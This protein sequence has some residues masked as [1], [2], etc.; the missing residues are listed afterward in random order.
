MAG[1][2]IAGKVIKQLSDVDELPFTL[3]VV[4][5]VLEED[6]DGYP[7]LHLIET[8]GICPDYVL[9][10]EPTDLRVY[11][12][13]RGRMEI[14]IATHGK[15]AHGAHNE[16]GIS[17]V[18]RMIPVLAAIEQLDN[19]LPPVAPLGKGSIT[20]SQIV[21]RA[22]S[23]C[24]VPDYCKIHLDRR[25]TVN[26]TRTSAVAQLE[27]LMAK[28][29]IHGEIT[30]PE[31]NGRSWK[32]T[33]VRQEAYFPTW[34]VDEDCPLVRAGVRTAEQILVPHQTTSFWSFSTN[35]VATA[36]RLGIPTIGFAPGREELAHSSREELVLADLFKATQF[37]AAFPFTLIETLQ[38][39][40]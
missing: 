23:L 31:Y 7:L 29:G 22:P 5:S 10:G 11:R 4:G 15:S 38:A 32:G 19:E 8:E 27:A 12:G 39:T 16:Q 18:N 20:T 25:L 26:E 33:A 24:S 13:Q 1:F 30:I 36:G 17:A 34:I 6:C 3:Y 9:L 2:L 37:Y 14:E 21:S 28:A 35:G 40:G